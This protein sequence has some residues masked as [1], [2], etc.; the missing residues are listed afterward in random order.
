MRSFAKAQR[1]ETGLPT[2]ELAKPRRV[3]EPQ[4][5]GNLSDALFGGVEQGG[6]LHGQQVVQNLADAFSRAPADNTREILFADGQTVGIKV[7]EVLFAKVLCGQGVKFGKEVFATGGA[8]GDDVFV[9]EH[10]GNVQKKR[11]TGRLN[12]LA[13]ETMV[14]AEQRREGGQLL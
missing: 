8:A 1:R 5:Q 13:Q 10:V 3:A 2:E 11:Q 12:P 4:A 9:G 6:G 14:G 7:N